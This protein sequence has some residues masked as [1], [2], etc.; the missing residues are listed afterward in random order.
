[1]RTIV[2]HQGFNRVEARCI[3]QVERARL[4]NL[5]TEER[6]LIERLTLSAQ[7]SVESRPQI[8]PDAKLIWR[9]IINHPLVI[10]IRCRLDRLTSAYPQFAERV[11]A[12]R[13]LVKERF[14]SIIERF[15]SHLQAAVCP[16]Q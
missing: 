7:R 2:F 6:R 4:N 10:E 1:M 14:L 13:S 11:Q 3:L 16:A 8:L 15:R 9:K 5:L 12:V